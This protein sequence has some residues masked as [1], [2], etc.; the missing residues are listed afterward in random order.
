[1]MSPKQYLMNKYLSS[2]KMC[3]KLWWAKTED[4]MGEKPQN[5][6]SHPHTHLLQDSDIWGGMWEV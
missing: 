2:V 5:M 4:G 1:M 6:D 3:C